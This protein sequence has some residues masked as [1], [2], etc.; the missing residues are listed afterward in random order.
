[1]IN[2]VDIFIKYA[3][4][5]LGLQPQ[6]GSP[7][8]SPSDSLQTR[9]LPK[10]GPAQP[11]ISGNCEV[12]ERQASSLLM[13]RLPLELRNMIWERVLGGNYIHMYWRDRDTLLGFICEEQKQCISLAHSSESNVPWDSAVTIKDEDIDQGKGWMGLLLSCRAVYFEASKILYSTNT[14]DFT[15]HWLNLNYLP[16]LLPISALTT[17]TQITM[18]CHGVQLPSAYLDFQLWKRTWETLFL[19]KALR[20]LHV[21]LVP[22]AAHTTLA[23]KTLMAAAE[24]EYLEPL[25]AVCGMG[26]K[27]FELVLPFEEKEDGR[28]RGELVGCKIIRV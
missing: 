12:Y 21:E 19:C 5:S 22:V 7:I 14:F 11:A 23:T 8:P 4:R 26:I 24:D 28:V 10:R 3:L 27:V 13:S 9:P 6:P 20:Y 25:R 16:W 18:T 1:M 2:Q 15:D 17:I